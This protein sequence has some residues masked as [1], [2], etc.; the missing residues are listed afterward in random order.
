M[1]HEFS[2]LSN[3]PLAALVGYK[4]ELSK[5]RISFYFF[6][7]ESVWNLNSQF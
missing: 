2:T 6:L 4:A 3:E 5:Q 1:T 7:I